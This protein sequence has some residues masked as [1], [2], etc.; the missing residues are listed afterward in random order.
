MNFLLRELFLHLNA[1][2]MKKVLGFINELT[3]NNNR[4]WF[5]TNKNRYQEALEIFRGF[6]GE[7]LTG[8]SKFDPTVGNLEPKDTI[9][10]IYKDVR[11]SKDKDPYKTHFGCWMAKGGRKS[12][13][14]GYY[15]HLESGKSFMAAG[16]WMPPKEQLKLIRQEILYNPD[17][18]LKLINTG[19]M[20][21]QYERGGKEDML[22]KG[23]VGFPKDFIHM[24][25]LKYKHYIWSRSYSDAAIQHTGFASSVTEDYKGLY[26]VVSYLNHAMSFTGNQ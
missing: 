3:E 24:E 13:D 12:T 11:F 20:N 16:V 7:L 26:P 4:D 9:F 25:E 19:V 23:P 14:A 5:N 15:F 10:R 1:F 21:D 8:I 6:A 17:S 18:Y 2:T 22:K